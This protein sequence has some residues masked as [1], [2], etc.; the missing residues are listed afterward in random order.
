MICLAH[1]INKMYNCSINVNVIS[2][3]TVQEEKT[4]RK[5]LIYAEF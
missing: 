3:L 1:E 4:V 2:S 5:W